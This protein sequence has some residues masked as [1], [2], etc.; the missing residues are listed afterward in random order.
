[1]PIYKPRCKA[2]LTILL[3]HRGQQN[4]KRE[5]Y[6]IDVQP[7]QCTVARNGYHEADTW[8]MEFD[9][10]LLPFDPDQVRQIEARI[11][12]WNST[13]NESSSFVWAIDRYEMIRGIADDDE[14]SMVG[15]DN[16]IKLTGRDY[17]GVLIDVVW[18]PK[19]KLP[20]G[21]K[22]D[23]MIQHVADAAAPEGTTARFR[24]INKSQDKEL[25]VVGGV[26]GKVRST[27]AKGEWV[28]PGKNHWDIIYD[29]AISSGYIA[30]VDTSSQEGQPLQPSI[31]ITDPAT[32]TEETL[33]QAPRL[34]YGKHLSKLSVKRKFGREKTPQQVLVAHDPYKKQDV[35]VV[36]PEQRNVIVTVF[37]TKI[38][39]DK[40]EQEFVPA[41]RGIFD[42]DRLLKYAKLR[43]YYRGR[44]ETTYTFETPCLSLTKTEERELGVNTSDDFDLLQLRPGSAVGVKFDPFNR[45]QLRSLTPGERAQHI[46]SLGYHPQ[47]ANVIARNLDTLT[48]FEQPYY[49]NTGEYDFDIDEGLNIKIEAVNFANQIREEQLAKASDL[50]EGVH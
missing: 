3:D 20:T 23:E 11:Y 41:P 9:A 17:T 18:D 5:R 28:K 47:I 33:R 39:V 27:K 16:S 29:L 4:L 45:E 12:M 34:A 48:A 15:E 10:R 8:N 43:F 25:P 42:R 1:M 46:L 19:T 32:Q 21:L 37:D 30:Y 26:I 38:A 50:A 2:R 13:G 40:D 44:A 35:Q 14:G 31:I 6:T 36:Y 24:V 49:F 7:R 22:L